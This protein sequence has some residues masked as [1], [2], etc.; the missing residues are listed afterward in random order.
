MLPFDIN[1]M[2]ATC[3][4]DGVKVVNN[5]KTPGQKQIYLAAS[6]ADN[7]KQKHIV[8][9]GSGALYNGSDNELTNQPTPSQG[10]ATA[11]T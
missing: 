11:A 7:F 8:T 10:C 2:I 4:R 9:L 1:A 3:A 5:A 6:E